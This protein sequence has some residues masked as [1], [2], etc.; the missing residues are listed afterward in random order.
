MTDI[1]RVIHQLLELPPNHRGLGQVMTDIEKVIHQLLEPHGFI[2]T[3]HNYNNCYDKD[4][5]SFSNISFNRNDNSLISNGD[6]IIEITETQVKLLCWGQT[7]W[8]IILTDL[9]DPNSLKIIED[10][11]KP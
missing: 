8:D 11:A 4:F 9:C 7:D 2:S 10:W 1:E 3:A 6:K 5:A